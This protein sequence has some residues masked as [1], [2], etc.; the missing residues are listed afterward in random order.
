MPPQ[1]PQFGVPEGDQPLSPA[2][3]PGVDQPV[4]PDELEQELLKIRGSRKYPK[5]VEHLQAKQDFYRQYYPGGATGG[6]PVENIDTKELGLWWK[7]AAIIVA[8][9]QAFIDIVENV[10]E[11]AKSADSKK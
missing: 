11:A 10:H 8:E 9:F 1:G 2:N 3:I 7:M 4:E 6:V 5:L